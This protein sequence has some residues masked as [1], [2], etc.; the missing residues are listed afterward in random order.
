M[1]D[2][3]KRKG[4]DCV[5][6][7]RDIRDRMSSEIAEMTQEELLRWFREHD[8]KDPVL[9]RFA[10]SRDERDQSTRETAPESV[11]L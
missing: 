1:T 8:Y 10:R 9:Q 6:M 7:V 3:I 2:G 4:F 11:K 5:Q